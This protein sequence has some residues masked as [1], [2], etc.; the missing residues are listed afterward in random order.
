[1]CKEYVTFVKSEFLQ[2]P[3]LNYSFSDEQAKHIRRTYT[4]HVKYM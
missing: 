2:T 1:M 4:I 3:Y